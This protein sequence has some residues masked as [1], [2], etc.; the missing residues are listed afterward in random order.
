MNIN[1]GLDSDFAL[2][3]CTG[4]GKTSANDKQWDQV[5]SLIKASNIVT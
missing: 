1:E 5:T 4:Q 3:S 2:Q